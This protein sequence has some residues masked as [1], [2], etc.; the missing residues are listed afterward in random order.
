MPATDMLGVT[1]HGPFLPQVWGN[2]HREDK[3][4]LMGADLG[5]KSLLGP[6]V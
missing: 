2:R 1:T 3:A 4:L 5:E 6:V